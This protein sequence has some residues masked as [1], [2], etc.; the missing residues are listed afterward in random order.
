MSSLYLQKKAIVA[1]IIKNIGIYRAGIQRF[2]VPVVKLICHLYT[3]YK[4][5]ILCENKNKSSICVNI[6]IFGVYFLFVY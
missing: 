2:A 4:A 5:I 1:L 3:N 6:D